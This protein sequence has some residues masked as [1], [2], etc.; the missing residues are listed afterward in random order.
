MAV[1]FCR[2]FQDKQSRLHVTSHC[3]DWFYWAGKNVRNR[4]I[5]TSGFSLLMSGEVWISSFRD[6]QF[7]LISWKV[8]L[9]T[10]HLTTYFLV[11]GQFQVGHRVVELVLII[12]RF[13]PNIYHRYNDHLNQACM[14]DSLHILGIFSAI[15]M[16][17]LHSLCLKAELI[18]GSYKF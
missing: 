2:L 17:K 10:L 9:M 7:I 1:W 5:S 8:I 13:G 12:K 14:K 3:H 15:F 18:T 6:C 16:K 11:I 4:V